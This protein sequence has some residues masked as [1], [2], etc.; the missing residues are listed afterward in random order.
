MNV[1]PC[2]QLLHNPIY[3][4][5]IIRIIVYVLKYSFMMKTIKLG[6][7]LTLKV[8]MFQ[9]FYYMQLCELCFFYIV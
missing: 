4:N 2:A 7:T 3:S 5:E 6:E 8:S 9:R 1:N